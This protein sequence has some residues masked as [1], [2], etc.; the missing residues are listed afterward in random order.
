MVAGAKGKRRKER[1]RYRTEKENK[2]EQAVHRGDNH[3]GLV[4]ED[5][6][7]DTQLILFSV[8]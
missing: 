1:R 2:R 4:R 7:Y 3:G 5:D 8:K 6:V